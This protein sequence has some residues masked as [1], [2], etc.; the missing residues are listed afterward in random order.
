MPHK[1]G[2]KAHNTCA[3]WYP[4]NRWPGKDAEVAGKSF[5]ALQVGVRVLWEIKVERFDGYSDF[6][7]KTAASISS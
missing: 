2:N 5:D 6:L 4:P 3:D 7:R 1:G